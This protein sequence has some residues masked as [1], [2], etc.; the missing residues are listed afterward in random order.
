M[1]DQ[2]DLKLP[3]KIL[4]QVLGIGL[5]LSTQSASRHQKTRT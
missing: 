3:S 4:E 1:K 5:V 2:D